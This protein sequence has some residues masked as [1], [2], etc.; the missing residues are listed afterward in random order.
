MCRHKNEGSFSQEKGVYIDPQF[1]YFLM[2]SLITTLHL[3]LISRSNVPFFCYY[4]Y[5]TLSLFLSISLF[6]YR[7]RRLEIKKN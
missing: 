4:Y 3:V 2:I 1:I 6:P 7:H 5:Y